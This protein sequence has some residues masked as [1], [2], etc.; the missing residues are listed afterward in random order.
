MQEVKHTPELI[1]LLMVLDTLP[2]EQRQSMIERLAPLAIGGGAARQAVEVIR[3]TMLT[4]GE[5]W[6]LRWAQDELRGGGA[7]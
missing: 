4:F 1:V 2:M 5:A 3:S 6:D 7:A